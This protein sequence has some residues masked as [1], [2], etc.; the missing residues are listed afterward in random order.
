MSNVIYQF[1]SD[2]KE[3]GIAAQKPS[4]MKA[5]TIFNDK[6]NWYVQV[7]KTTNP[8]ADLSEATRALQ[9]HLIDTEI[10]VSAWISNLR[11][12]RHNAG[13]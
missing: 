11:W 1:G 6:G 4:R 13:R 7:P 2:C 12:A 9:N 8:M 3:I 5:Q 10:S